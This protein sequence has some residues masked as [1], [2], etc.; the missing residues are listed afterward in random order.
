MLYVIQIYRN[1]CNYLINKSIIQYVINK[2]Y[3]NYRS[4][5]HT[6]CIEKLAL[7]SRS[8]SGED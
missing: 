3:N 4:L 5:L 1:T 6:A 2:Y 7:V 8:A